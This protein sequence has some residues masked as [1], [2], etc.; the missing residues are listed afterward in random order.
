MRI[1]R[2]Q[3]RGQ[4]T[5]P[6]EIREACGIEPG[7]NLLFLPVGPAS[8]ECRVLP[9]ESISEV[10]ERYTVAGAAPHLRALSEA[11]ERETTERYLRDVPDPTPR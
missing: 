2:V 3:A 4:V 11:A 10:I 1:S 9:R 8:F 6:Q 5:V 7:S